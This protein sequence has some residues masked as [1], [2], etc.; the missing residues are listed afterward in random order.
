MKL[1]PIYLT[2]ITS[3][4]ISTPS[5]GKKVL[6]QLVE[7]H[8]TVEDRNS[9]VENPYDNGYKEERYHFVLDKVIETFNPEFVSRGQE[10]KILRD[11]GDGAV[12]AW[13]FRIGAEA[14]LEVPGGMS[15][16]HLISEEGF[17]MT[18][19]HELGHLLGGFP[20]RLKISFEGQSD[21]YAPMKCMEKILKSLKVPSKAPSVDVGK[22]CQ[23]SFCEER[24]NGIKSLTS[25]YA[26]LEKAPSPSLNTP[27]R[28]Q[29][30]QTLS[31]HPPAQ[32]RFDTMIRSLGCS[33]R[34]PFSYSSQ[35]EGACA[36][37]FSRPKC[38]YSANP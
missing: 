28:G 25:Y 12:N 16:Y 33:N 17:L 32:C 19:C 10:L 30:R 27:S 1:N 29:V 38:W 4:F 22:I 2:L 18:I 14:W 15:R 21:Y 3:L 9:A 7:E 37:R 24:L 36:D 20:H 35:K 34:E 26:F 11:W 23:G 8:V 31:S 13:A 5:F 6:C